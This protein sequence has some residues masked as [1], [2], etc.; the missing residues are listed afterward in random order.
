MKKMN[1]KVSFTENTLTVKS[2]KSTLSWEV[3]KGKVVRTKKVN[4]DKKE[5]DNASYLSKFVADYLAVL[6]GSWKSR[7]VKMA[8]ALENLSANGISTFRTLNNNIRK[9]FDDGS[10]TFWANHFYEGVRKGTGVRSKLLVQA[11]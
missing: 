3:L 4:L 10:D 7:I 2:G 6:K 8:T 5:D 11:A 9:H 1:F